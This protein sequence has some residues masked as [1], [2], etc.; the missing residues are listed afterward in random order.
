MQRPSENLTRYQSSFLRQL[1][2]SLED[3]K[4][5]KQGTVRWCF[6]RGLFE[7]RKTGA[8]RTS[9][10]E[11]CLKAVTEADVNRREATR[12]G[13]FTEVIRHLV[14]VAQFE[15]RQEREDRKLTIVHRKVA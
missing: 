14:A 6:K 8:F 11:Q 13:D 10:G 4:K 1:P 5:K 9:F 7:I 2:L 15:R 3:L 12:Y